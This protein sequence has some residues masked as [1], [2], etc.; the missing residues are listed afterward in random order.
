MDEV[1]AHLAAARG[2]LLHELS[3]L[4]DEVFNRII[5]PDK[6]SIAQVCHH[7][8][9]TETLFIKAIRFG[10]KR[11]PLLQTERKNVEIV[12]DMATK[13]E[14]P[15]VARPDSGPFQLPQILEQLHKSRMKLI[16][17]L[18]GIEDPSIFKEIAVNHPRF[19]DL[20]LD[21]W[22]EL[23]YMHEQRHTEQI[24]SLK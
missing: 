19:G 12:L 8:W 9:L 24:I 4:N 18:D 3:S 5:E 11:K 23:L 20:P 2:R 6:W 22:I 21:Q 16:E 1:K 10:I 13:Y 17:L 14:A 15:E 7:L